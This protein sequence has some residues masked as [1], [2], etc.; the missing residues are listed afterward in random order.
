MDYTN[1][2]HLLFRGFLTDSFTLNGVSLVL[3]SLNQ[4]EYQ[5]SLL[6]TEGDPEKQTLYFIGH[7]IFLIDRQNVLPERERFL[8]AFTEAI[9]EWP[10]ALL[11]ALL[12]RIKRLNEK[13]SKS[14]QDV[15]AYSF[16]EFSRQNWSTYKDHLLNDS[17]I[18]G[19]E[20]THILGLNHHQKLWYFYN[21][22]EDEDL[23]Y[24]RLWSHTKF[25]ASIHSSDVKKID[26]Q[27]KTKKREIFAER[28]AKFS[29][30]YKRD[31]EH[32][33]DQVKVT[34]E[35]VSDLLDQMKADISGQKDFH[36]LVVEQHQQKVKA[37]MEAKQREYEAQ[38][39]ESRSKRPEIQGNSSYVTYTEKD[40]EIMLAEK[41]AEKRNQLLRG[42][43]Q[44]E[45]AYL[46]QKKRLEKWGVLPTQKSSEPPRTSLTGTPLEEFY[47]VTRPDL[48]K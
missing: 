17:K 44:T 45:Q 1:V 37:Q 46:E 35:R 20:G 41:R 48:K 5:R 26:S 2:E 13:A 32:G 3:K 23:H 29:G 14:L 21:R 30:T 27:D 10:E 38:I 24:D 31:A 43:F 47:E 33:P 19:V 9:Q 40:L 25:L 15:E 8:T 22:R 16:G 42:D 12:A 34:Q 18:T 4:G 11:Y 39:A 36:D 7:S 28:Q 6:Y